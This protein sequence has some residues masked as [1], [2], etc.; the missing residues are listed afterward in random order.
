M[1]ARSRYVVVSDPVSAPGEGRPVRIVMSTRSLATFLIPAALWALVEAGQFDLVPADQLAALRAAQVLVPADEDELAS[2]LSRNRQAAVSADIL[3]ECVQPTSACNLGCG[4]CGQAHGKA[5]LSAAHQ[6]L[7][8]ARIDARLR[9]GTYRQ[10]RIGWFGG[11]PLSALPV[12]RRLTPALRDVA[13]RYGCAFDAHVVTNGLSL[14][15]P[16]ARELVQ[17]MGITEIEVTLDGSAAAH[18][19]RRHTKGGAPTFRRILDNV[20]ALARADDVE[21]ALRIRCNVDRRNVEEP[22]RL[23]ELLADEGLQQRLSLYFA[24]VHDWSNG[25]DRLSL[26]PEDYAWREL[27]WLALMHR[28]GFATPLLPSAKPLVCMAVN[29]HA[30]LVDPF[31]Q[32]FNCTEV[33]LVPAYGTPNVFALG[34]LARADRSPHADRL[35]DFFDDVAAGDYGCSRCPMLPVCGGACPKAWSEGARPCPSAKRNMKDRLV[36]AYAL[37]RLDY[38]AVAALS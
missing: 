31:G 34:T 6:D 18:D 37:S 29:P 12:M 23:I 4:Y 7:L 10:L 14:S 36:L 3:Y 16:V 19:S 22:P 26:D 24:P 2:V 32:V 13:E 35:A 33:S 17:Q 25:A 8:V 20:C 1:L 9:S 15:P 5:A 30:E 28:R 21:T 27:D 11:E 38:S